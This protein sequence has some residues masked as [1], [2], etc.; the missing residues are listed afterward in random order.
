MAGGGGA[1]GGNVYGRETRI[2][3][4]AVVDKVSVNDSHATILIWLGIEHT[5]N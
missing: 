2:R 4:K 3:H 5:E 1:K